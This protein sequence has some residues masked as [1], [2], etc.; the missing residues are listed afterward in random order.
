MRWFV[1]TGIL[2]VAIALS[3]AFFVHAPHGRTQ[4]PVSEA[5]AAVVTIPVEGMSCVSCAGD[6]E[7]N[8]S[9]DRWCSRS[10]SQPG[11]SYSANPIR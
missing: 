6:G 5:G 4:L 9:N 11:T 1:L 7:K 2:L 3:V 10:R 8:S